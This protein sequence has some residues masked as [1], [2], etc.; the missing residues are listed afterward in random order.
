MADDGSPPI[1]IVLDE[2]DDAATDPPP[3]RDWHRA[4][5]T[6]AA[7]VA[8]LALLWTA[9]SVA[10]LRRSSDRQGCRTELETRR[11]LLEEEHYRRGDGSGDV[12]LVAEDRENILAQA[13]DCGLDDFADVL[14]RRYG[15]DED[16]EDGSD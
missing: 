9:T 4:A 2:A 13:R 16:D 8:A 14:E 3:P 1:E 11:W 7:V 12:D 10:G 6:A 5:R 15:S